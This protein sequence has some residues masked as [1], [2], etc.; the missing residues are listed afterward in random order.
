MFRKVSNLLLNN[1]SAFNID[2]LLTMIW[3]LYIICNFGNILI[4]YD[5]FNSLWNI[6]LM[7][8]MSSVSCVSHLSVFFSYFLWWQ[9]KNSW[10]FVSFTNCDLVHWYIKFPLLA[11]NTSILY[12]FYH[13]FLSCKPVGKALI[14]FMK[15]RYLLQ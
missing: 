9:K 12:I 14:N 1:I 8:L 11:V 15:N 13:M 3:G 4:Q 5:L 7:S 10:K 6:K 2:N